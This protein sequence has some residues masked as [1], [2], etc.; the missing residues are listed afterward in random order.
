LS[1][2]EQAAVVEMNRLYGVWLQDQAEKYRQ[3][4]IPAQPWATLA[5][6]LLAAIATPTPPD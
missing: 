2:V 1:R 5:E 3:A 4:W 6:R